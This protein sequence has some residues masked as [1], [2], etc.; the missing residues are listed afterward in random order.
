MCVQVCAARQDKW[1]FSTQVHVCF[2]FVSPKADLYSPLWWNNVEHVALA[3]R[4]P[5]DQTDRQAGRQRQ[6]APSRAHAALVSQPRH[7]LV[8]FTLQPYCWQCLCTSSVGW[9]FSRNVPC[10]WSQ[11]RASF[12]STIPILNIFKGNSVCPRST[13]IIK[14]VVSFVNNLLENSW[15]DLFLSRFSLTLQLACRAGVELCADCR[16]CCEHVT[17]VFLQTNLTS[18]NL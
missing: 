4:R 5:I 1:R 11:A 6:M 2:P 8:P 14:S 17:A 12:Q 9:H 13:Q 15:N 3:K 18:S 16:P 7:W 10:T